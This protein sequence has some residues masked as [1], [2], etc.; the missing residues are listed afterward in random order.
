MNYQKISNNLK[1]LSVDM[2]NKANSG[3]PGVCMGLSD[4]LSVLSTHLNIS[5]DYPEH[6]NRDR[7]IFSGGHAS[8]LLYSFLHLSGF[9]ISL[10]E[11][12]NF[13]QLGSKTPG[14]PEI[15]TQGVEI[16]TGPLG[17][18]IANAVG[19][20]MAIKF[21]NSQL[22]QALSSKVYCLC[23]DGDLQEGISYEA[24]SLAQ[25]QKLNNLILIYD[26]NKISIEG[27]TNITFNEDIKA[28][29]SSIDFMVIE[30]N[31]HDY[32]QINQ[33][34][35]SAKNANKA[36]LILANT[37][38]ANGALELQGSE[39]SHGAPLGEE[40][41]IRA[42]QNA[43]YPVEEFYIDLEVKE[44]LAKMSARANEIFTNFK[45]ENNDFYKALNGEIKYD[46]SKI[47]L[48]KMDATRNTNEIILNELANSIPTFLGG[49]ADLAPSNKTN[50]KAFASF[51]EN[52]KNIHFGI[53][54]H[55]MAAIINAFARCNLLAFCATFLVF[56]DYLK[57]ALR[58]SA[59]M[60]LK[61]FYIFSHDSIGVGEDG[62]THQPIEQ[63]ST[64]R[65]IP[66]LLTF[67]PACMAENIAAW[68]I[69]LK[70]QS[71]SAF[72]L[73]RSNTNYAINYIPDISN[74]VYF[75]YEIK[76]Y[77]H[78]IISNGSEVKLAID[79]AKILN[80][81]GIKTSVLSMPC[82]NL[83]DKA[84][85]EFKNKILKDKKVIAIEAAASNELYK[86]ASKCFLM[87]S[88]G[89]SAKE[90]DVFKHFGFEADK[91]ANEI[92]KA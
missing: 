15:T 69:A 35:L 24:L 2:I 83:F 8:A 11:L 17:Q 21:I 30:I 78:L 79:V 36:V 53:R 65:N 55:A 85:C 38:I 31:G 37:N 42:K 26:C 87:Q 16:A 74:G 3:H 76:D 28:R 80:E 67:R 45:V 7:L 32:E 88:F 41:S 33:A 81:K 22:N 59:L 27:K 52:G 66:N 51:N 60:K 9:D 4:I 92:I 46:L 68:Q 86:Y 39:K 57:P 75:A 29:F 6:L 12:K 89:E 48:N 58:L 10:D 56:S 91:I 49:S 84:S 43:A 47:D 20:A 13:R 25:S 71:P 63:L 73:S 23:G 64:L 19:Y 77:T 72:V 70:H 44:E 5:K 50:L 14:H 62:P 90:K 82:F 40:L 18:G 1:F 61:N 34:L 54:E